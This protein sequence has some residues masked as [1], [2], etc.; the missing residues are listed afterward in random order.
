MSTTTKLLSTSTTPSSKSES[1]SESSIIVSSSESVSSS[2][3]AIT[4]S[5]D[6]SSPTRRTNDRYLLGNSRNKLA[7]S[8][9]SRYLVS[10]NNKH[11]RGL[12]RNNKL[13]NSNLKLT[14]HALENNSKLTFAPTLSSI[15]ASFERP[16]DDDYVLETIMSFENQVSSESPKDLTTPR[17]YGGYNPSYSTIPNF[18]ANKWSSY[19]VGQPLTDNKPH[20]V[21]N[22]P[23]IHKI[24]SKWSDNP[25]VVFGYGDTTKYPQHQSQAHINDLTNQLMITAFTPT[26][27]YFDDLPSVYG[28]QLMHSQNNKYPSLVTKAPPVSNK[29]SILS[30]RPNRYKDYQPTPTRYQ[31]LVSVSGLLD[32]IESVKNANK[33]SGEDGIKITKIKTKIDCKSKYKK[34]KKDGCKEDEHE[35]DKGQIDDKLEQQPELEEHQQ[36][37]DFSDEDKDGI[38]VVEESPPIKQEAQELSDPVGGTGIELR[39][40]NLP[41]VLGTLNQLGSSGNQGVR[42]PFSGSGLSDKN[43][44]ILSNLGGGHHGKKK[45][46]GKPTVGE[47]GEVATQDMG[48]MMAT[49]III[50]AI[51]NPM[52]FGVWGL[53]FAPM[54]ATMFGGICLVLYYVLKSP[55]PSPSHNSGWSSYMNPPIVIREK[56]SPIPIQ[57]THLHKYKKPP[58]HIYSK[59]ETYYEEPMKAEAPYGKGPTYEPGYSKGPN[60]DTGYGKG[61]I[62]EPLQESPTNY[63][64][65]HYDHFPSMKSKSTA[66]IPKRFSN[67]KY[68]DEFQNPGPIPT[69]LKTSPKKK[70]YKYKLL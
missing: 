35:D 34:H 54:A 38:I 31:S 24:I 23:V 39:P 66:Q 68:F 60:T 12:I 62:Y 56:H 48:T 9:R 44:G 47:E 52:N 17:R 7:N 70:D 50:M 14:M 21:N 59:P 51:F 5:Q 61:P 33:Y 36:E 8:N 19:N 42:R 15:T 32:P 3:E 6:D 2:T 46:K 26:H 67:H 37:V 18:P 28:Q 40:L 25:N 49:V 11:N 64:E 69:T 10:S 45:K 13:I 1:S 53:I 16:N 57:I 58:V 4:V 27:T 29:V 63:H 55:N 43:D 65:H 41:G 22:K 30:Q 20:N